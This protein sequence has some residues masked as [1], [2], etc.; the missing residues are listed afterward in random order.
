MQT[1][2]HA[3]AVRGVLAHPTTPTVITASADKSVTIAPIAVQ[4][5]IAL[6]GKPK[7]IIVSPDGQRIVIIGPGKALRVS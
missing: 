1:F 5:A 6:G 3:G 2:A 7:G 4:R